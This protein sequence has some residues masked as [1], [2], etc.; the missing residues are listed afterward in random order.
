MTGPDE[1]AAQL[2]GLVLPLGRCPTIGPERG[3]MIRD[4]ITVFF[5]SLLRSNPVS[6]HP[7]GGSYRFVRIV[8]WRIVAGMQVMSK[9]GLG[10]TV[11]NIYCRPEWR[12]HGHMTDLLTAAQDTL[13]EVGFSQDLT[14]DGVA[15]ISSLD[16]DPFAEA[17]SC[18]FMA[19]SAEMSLGCPV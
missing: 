16:D 9:T 4:G 10:G 15:W 2:T 11:V 5:Q 3:F 18:G 19:S 12:R 7:K 8:D 6:P 17:G 1:L 13:G 14:S